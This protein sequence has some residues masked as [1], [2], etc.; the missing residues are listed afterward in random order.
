MN[1]RAAQ[2]GIIWCVTLVTTTTLAVRALGQQPPV[3]ATAPYGAPGTTRATNPTTAS[4]QAAAPRRLPAAAQG[5]NPNVPPGAPPQ[6]WPG[7][8]P[9]A[10]PVPAGRPTAP[11]QPIQRTSY[12]TSLKQPDGVGAAPAA[13]PDRGDL[14]MPNVMQLPAV[15]TS[16]E[17]MWTLPQLESAAIEFNPAMRHSLAQI[18]SARGDAQQAGLYPNP[19][20][21]TN[22]PEVFA[23][24]NSS[25]NA[26]FMQDIVVKGKLRLDRAAANEVV[27]QREHGLTVNRFTLLTAIRQQF[28][29]VLAQQ[30]RMEL[31]EQLR[32]IAEESVRAAKGR[33][34]GGDGSLSEVLL[35]QNELQRAEIALRNARTIL[36]AELRQLSAIVGRPDL[37]I[38]RVTGD[39]T[40][41]FPDYDPENLR[42]FVIS[43]N[44]QVQIARREIDRQQIL[45]RRA[46]VEPYPNVRVGP[47]YNSNLNPIP[48]T[49]Q[50]WFT[51]QFDIPIWNRNQGNI[52]STQADLVDA[53]AS[54]GVLQND[55]LS[56]VEDVL[57]RYLAARQMEEKVR[58]QILP[59]AQR[60]LDVVRSAY[61]PGVVDISTLLQAQ[62]SLSETSLNYYETL[63]DVWT[64]A[65]EIAKLLQLE[66]F[67]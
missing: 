20:F 41:G 63:E 29:A 5:A 66:R 7:Q 40:S 67:P 26:G 49:T 39:L 28:Y 18:D 32:R 38:E 50:F 15:Q 43:Q 42:I 2:R 46:R 31:L 30:R 1:N 10:P 16:V 48:G 21:D 64:T 12:F 8:A 14:P 27:R 52:R 65:A 55:L 22:N 57:G 11:A 62:R 4:V 58:T 59:T 9:A 53:V 37:R 33:L 3:A 36:Q 24:Q 51:V 54:L 34:E 56:Q 44:A 45:L 23:G 60:A 13:G 19:R 61:I 6:R 47:T 25:Y 35:T 17:G